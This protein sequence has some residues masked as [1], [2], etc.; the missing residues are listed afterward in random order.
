MK[1]EILEIV[2]DRREAKAE[3]EVWSE[4][5]MQ[6]FSYYQTDAQ[7]KLLKWPVKRHRREQHK[8]YLFWKI[9]EF[10][11]KFNSF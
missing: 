7:I 3:T 11:I 9:P 10:K 5:Y 4:S 2:K 1:E 6:P 8:I